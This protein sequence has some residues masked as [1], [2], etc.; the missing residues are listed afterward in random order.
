MSAKTVKNSGWPV[1]AES[2]PKATPA[3]WAWAAVPGIV[4]VVMAI[5]QL[6]SFNDFRDTLRPMGLGVPTVWAV[7]IILA[8]LW[9]AASFFRIRLSIG[10]RAVSN[11]LAGLVAVFWF[12]DNVQLTSTG[13]AQMQNSDFFGRF[14]AQSPGWWTVLEATVLLF[15]VVY[16]LALLRENRQTILA[17]K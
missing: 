15:W 10:F 17:V 12:V 8:E 14:L 3:Q 7:C 1:K 5:L 11:F 9:G 2:P 16:E 13:A 6:I 4:L